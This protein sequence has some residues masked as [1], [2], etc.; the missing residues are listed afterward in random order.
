M[1][2]SATRASRARLHVRLPGVA[3]RRDEVR[4]DLHRLV[5][6]DLE[7]HDDAGIHKRALTDA[8]LRLPAFV[9]L[10]LHFALEDIER[11]GAAVRVRGRAAARVHRDV[12]EQVDEF[13]V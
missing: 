12:A 1:W 9:R 6:D 13:P 10:E 2:R 5:P 3:F 7:L 11:F 8:E 4:E